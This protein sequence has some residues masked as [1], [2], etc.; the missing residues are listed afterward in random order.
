MELKRPK[1]S[2][3]FQEKLKAP[4]KHHLQ[5]LP[6]FKEDEPQALADEVQKPALSSL[7]KKHRALGSFSAKPGQILYLAEQ[8]LV[9]GALGTSQNWH[10]ERACELFRLLGAKLFSLKELSLEFVLREKLVE[11]L[12]YHSEQKDTLSTLLRLDLHSKPRSKKLGKKQKKKD[13]SE[14]ESEFALDYISDMNLEDL[15]C[16]LVCCMNIGAESMELLKNTNK[17]KASIPISISHKRKTELKGLKNILSRGRSISE[18]LHGTRYLASLPGN[19]MNPESYETYARSL[20]QEFRLKIKVFDRK[21]LQKM[22]CG[23]I[24]AVG[25]GSA[26]PPRMILLEYQ[27]PKKKIFRP[28]L[29][30]GKGITFDTGGISLK[31]SAEMHEMKYDMCGSAVALHG[32]ALAAAQKL[33]LP[34]LAL[35]GVAENMPD[36]QAIKPGD[37]YTAYDGSTVEVQNTD[38]EGRLVLG[39]L[40]AYGARNYDPL[41]ILDFATLTGACV[42]ALGHDATAVMTASQDLYARIKRASERSLDRSWPMPHWSVYGTGLKSEI[43][44][45]RN[46]AG[47]AAGTLSAMRFLARF[48]PPEIPWAHFDIAGTAWRSKAY[49]SQGKGASA[50]GVRFLEAF[51]QDLI[52]K[53]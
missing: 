31:P 23:G 11:A 7:L 15:L 32:I 47:R 9:L 19:Y 42:I 2:F 12:H 18:M 28:L 37:V 16:Q 44:D 34:V 25:Q 3:Y 30:V 6:V 13:D 10:P 52:K 39:D 5:I 48:V 26:V 35:L 43:A 36:G 46:I 50:W 8:S 14:D 51:M 40:L 53:T 41:C 27:P 17:T 20:A 38:A 1:Q 45:Q 4:A 29:L 21:A 24:L 33:E 49:A 22:A